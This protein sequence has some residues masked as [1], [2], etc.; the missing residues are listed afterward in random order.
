MIRRGMPSGSGDMTA[1]WR[2]RSLY[3][4]TRCGGCSR[5]YAPTKKACCRCLI[6]TATRSARPRQKSTSAAT[7]A[8]TIW[9]PPTF[10]GLAGSRCPINQCVFD[11]FDKG[12]GR[13]E[14]VRGEILQVLARDRVD[15]EADPLRLGE[16]FRV[17]HCSHEGLAQ[18]HDA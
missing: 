4:R 2:H 10:D 5:E 13:R 7:G 18:R 3:W 1:R 17:L 9:D 16:Q 8:P 6:P 15:G 11:L 14:Y 12:R